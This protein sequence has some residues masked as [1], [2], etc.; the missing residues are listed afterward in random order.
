MTMSQL[1]DPLDEL[2][3][4]YVDDDLDE[5]SRAQIE[6]DDEAMGRVARFRQ[7]RAALADVEALPEV[8]VAEMVATALAAAEHGS[9]THQAAVVSF[10][11]RQRVLAWVGG[12]VAA[13]AVALVAAGVGPRLGGDVPDDVA[14]P[15]VDVAADTARSDQSASVA[16]VDDTT[17]A[18]LE[19]APAEA[20]G[21]DAEPPATFAATERTP[22]GGEVVIASDDELRAYLAAFALPE[23]GRCATV[24]G[25]SVHG[26][27]TFEGRSVEVVYD[28][29]SDM[30]LLADPITCDVVRSV[31]R[32][33]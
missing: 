28:A 17:V 11:R 1:P 18:A 32:L 25:S 23:P 26:V 2:A 12:A 5:S 7:V 16:S 29:N 21:M 15:A 14:A 3:S 22:L 13:A 8:Q 20:A 24:P 33:P 19:A 6:H 31:S 30:I 4:R 27:V 10:R 9:P